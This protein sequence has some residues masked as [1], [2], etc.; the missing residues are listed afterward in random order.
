MKI[1][2]SLQ[3]SP[4]DIIRVSVYAPLS[5]LSLIFPHP[6]P[7]SPFGESG[8]GNPACVELARQISACLF[9]PALAPRVM[10]D[11]IRCYGYVS[12]DKYPP[13]DAQSMDVEPIDV[14]TGGIHLIFDHQV[15]SDDEDPDVVHLWVDEE[16]K[17]TGRKNHKT[18]RGR[19]NDM[20]KM[21][22]S[23]KDESEGGL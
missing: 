14:P 13:E 16:L 2:Q 15:S 11:P 19:A 5:A 7:V 17:V 23:I 1:D 8:V 18:D 21:H 22:E 9:T 6:F 20:V 3:I 10:P 4:D 12:R